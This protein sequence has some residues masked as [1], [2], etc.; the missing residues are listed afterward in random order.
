MIKK[1]AKL[2]I[3]IF[4][5]VGAIVCFKVGYEIRSLVIITVIVV[6]ILLLLF[7]LL[8]ENDDYSKNLIVAVGISVT[9][10]SWFV[11]GYLNHENEKKRSLLDF[12]RSTSQSKR[13]LKVKFL[14]DAYFRLENSDF[15]DSAPDGNQ[16]IMY[17]QVYL[18][19]SESALTSIQ[20]LG[21]DSTVKLANL[22]ILSGGKKHFNELL[23]SL[24]NELRNELALQPL[25]NVKEYD[26]TVSRTYRKIGAPN[27]LTPDQQFQLTLKLCEY[28]K[29]LLE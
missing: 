29:S 17:D 20:L 27:E 24:R 13:D 14:I 19:Y 1:I 7:I 21:T 22:F 8:P 15:R 23:K 26:P 5:L 3:V 11:T 25:P 12:E 6:D 28:G 10:L 18:K 4:I 9:I 16:K 2:L